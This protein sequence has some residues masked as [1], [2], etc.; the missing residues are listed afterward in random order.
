MGSGTPAGARVYEP[1]DVLVNMGFDLE[2]SRVAIAAAGGDIDRAVRIVMEDAK[3][4]TSIEAGEWEFEGDKGWAAFDCDT[5]RHLSGAYLRGDSAC[6][7]RIAGNR[8][9]VDFDNLTQL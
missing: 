9:L 2:L 1:V 5:D 7:L 3:A 4:H 8:Y 6:E